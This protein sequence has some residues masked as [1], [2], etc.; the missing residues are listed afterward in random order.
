MNAERKADAM[1]DERNTRVHA[2]ECIMANQWN[3]MENSNVD[4]LETQSYKKK[5]LSELCSSKNRTYEIKS[6]NMKN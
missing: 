1:P 2:L 6:W 4:I 5:L 3:K